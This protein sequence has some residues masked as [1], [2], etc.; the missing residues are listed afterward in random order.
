MIS[1]CALGGR[2]L[3]LLVSTQI[4]LRVGSAEQRPFTSAQAS[5]S[6]RL[7]QA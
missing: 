2:F 5:V 3:N 7:G 4:D 1:L 6:G